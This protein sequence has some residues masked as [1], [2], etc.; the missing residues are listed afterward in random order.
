MSAGWR[1][2]QGE[3]EGRKPGSWGPGSGDGRDVFSTGRASQSGL[4]GRG[5]GEA[6]TGLSQGAT[7]R[8]GCAETCMG[9]MAHDFSESGIGFYVRARKF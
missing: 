6:V 9:L 2:N 7:A 5:R 4:E 8:G 1:A 3:R